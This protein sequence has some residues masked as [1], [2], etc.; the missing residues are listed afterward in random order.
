VKHPLVT[1][2]VQCEIDERVVEVSKKYLPF[3]AK[4]LDNP[5]VTLFIGDGF[6]FIK[7]HPEEFDVII[8]DSSDPVGPAA[9]LFQESYFKLLLNALR[10]GGLICSQVGTMWLEDDLPFISSLMRSCRAL[11]PVVDYAYTCVPTYPG[12]QIGF[13]LC[14]TNPGTK[15]QEPI[16]RLT[17]KDCKD[18]NLRYYS[19]NMHTAA[20][21]LP[22]FAQAVVSETYH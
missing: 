15:F 8:T 3:M 11:Y 13:A 22:C 1:S 7:S 6:E 2:V 14:S 10:P 5:K 20:F 17:G 4:G 19:S 12:G 18:M 16:H 9:S 21:V